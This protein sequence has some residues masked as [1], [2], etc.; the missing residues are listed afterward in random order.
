MITTSA[1]SRVDGRARSQRSTPRN[2]TSG[3]YMPP[4]R[5]TIGECLGPEVF[6]HLGE[7]VNVAL[8]VFDGVLHRERPVLL[9]SWRHHHPTVAL[10]QPAE[11]GEGLV[12][13]QVV[14]IVAHALRPVG[15]AATRAERDHVEGKL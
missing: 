15:D 7:V 2:V 1:P 10:I 12:D 5:D 6:R 13:L 8:N 3:P 4:R 9:G 11:V 14:A